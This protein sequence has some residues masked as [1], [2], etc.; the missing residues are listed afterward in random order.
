MATQKR[1]YYEVLGVQRGASEEEIK[2]AYRKLAKKYHPDVNPNDKVAEKKFKEVSEAYEVLSDRE[3]RARYDQ[4]GHAGTDPN[5]GAYGGTGFGG[6]GFDF[7]MGGFGDIFE[8][9]FG[10]RSTRTERA[11]GP[12]RG[13]D[14]E[15]N[16]ELA[17]EEAARGVEKTVSVSRMEHCDTCK[18]SG[19][20]EGTQPK[21]CPTC[22]GSGK[23]RSSQNT[24][25]GSFSTITT[26]PTCRGEGNVIESP[27]TV[28][29]GRGQVRKTK[30][31]MLIFQKALITGRLFHFA[32]RVIR[33]GVEVRQVIY[34]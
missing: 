31:S 9:F 2:R 16:L 12:Q 33:D 7:D 17:F 27:C 3:K 22:K 4:F 26:C 20:K 30:K 1:D 6:A 29:S 23:V 24:L 19:A 8:T 32:A 10:G 21:T 28:C 14:I 15:R 11:N 18:G 13:R 5:F 25:F 34:I